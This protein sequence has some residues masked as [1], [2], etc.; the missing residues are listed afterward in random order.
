MRTR[1]SR[2]CLRRGTA[3]FG[4]RRIHS[5]LFTQG[6]QAHSATVG[7][8]DTSSGQR[9]VAIF[10]AARGGLYSVY[11]EGALS[12]TGYLVS[13]PRHVEAFDDEASD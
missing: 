4:P 7:G 11:A 9:C 3:R 6:R 5:I 1:S 13:A 2:R 12:R 10:E 8:Q